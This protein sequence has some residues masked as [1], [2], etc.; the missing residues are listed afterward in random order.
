MT[1]S[2]NR[3]EIIETVS[4]KLG[5]PEEQA[6]LL[7]EGVLEEIIAS[8]VQGETVKIWGFGAFDILGKTKRMGRNP[9]TGEEYLIEPHLT[10]IFHAS[11]CLKQKFNTMDT[12]IPA[13]SLP[14]QKN[15]KK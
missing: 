14:K 5:L 1:E 2:F 8:L 9:K 15:L 6:S 4:T 10:V 11:E 12:S 13:Q 3:A 7:V